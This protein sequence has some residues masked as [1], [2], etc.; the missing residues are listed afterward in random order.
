MYHNTK[1]NT[2]LYSCQL[3]VDLQVSTDECIDAITTIQDVN[4]YITNV[5][6][7]NCIG[8]LAILK[9]SIIELRCYKLRIAK[10]E[11]M[12]TELQHTIYHFQKVMTAFAFRTK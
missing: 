7:H 3:N 1:C 5:E 8:L 4:L 2:T 9:R 12:I 11:F 10:L 6:L